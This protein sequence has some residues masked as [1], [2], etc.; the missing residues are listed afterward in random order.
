[1]CLCKLGAR[2]SLLIISTSGSYARLTAA[3]ISRAHYR[4][5]WQTHLG[6]PLSVELRR[7][8]SRYVDGSQTSDGRPSAARF[9]DLV[10]SLVFS[11]WVALKRAGYLQ[12]ATCSSLLGRGVFGHGLGTF[13]YGVLGQLTGQKQANCCLDL[14]TA[15]GG[16][17]V[18][19]SQT[20]SLGGDPFENVIDERV[21]DRHGF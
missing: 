14:A 20:A 5:K 15:D 21:H 18:V 17:L 16:S 12:V 11:V 6:R 2:E 10:K 8:A 13:G 9:L 4:R 1:M 3:R 7:V 19:V